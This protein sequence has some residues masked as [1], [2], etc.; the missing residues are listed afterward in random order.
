ML[1][2]EYI[3]TWGFKHAIRGMRNAK[4]SWDRSDSY[5]FKNGYIGENDLGLMRNLFKASLN[6]NHAHRKYLRD[7]HVSMDVVA[8]M[9][10]W[11]EM[12]TYK[13]GVTRLS[14]STMHTV[15]KKR[16]TLDDFSCEHLTVK[17]IC[18]LENTIGR[19]N[20][21]REA[22]IK[23]NNK[24]DWWQIIQLLPSSY[25]QRATLDFNY[26]NVIA[27]LNQRGGHKLDEWGEFCNVLWKLPYIK[28]IMGVNE[29]EQK[30]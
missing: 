7:I 22:F 3:E 26:E 4:N 6:Q 24:E 28:D 30:M 19:L 1:K 9:Y 23:N 10:W 5:A 29:N 25:N 17:S 27:I 8:P 20:R 12:D 18:V 11:K 16:F 14:C 21:C 15:H 13:I 2:V